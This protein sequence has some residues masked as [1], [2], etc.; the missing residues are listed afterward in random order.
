MKKSILNLVF[1][2]L[3]GMVFIGCVPSRKYEECRDYRRS[4]QGDYD[5]LNDEARDLRKENVAMREELETLRLSDDECQADLKLSRERY[6]ELDNAQR[7]LI[8]RY[9]RR[10]KLYQDMS[11][12]VAG[13][14]KEL[15]DKIS[16]Q[17]KELDRK[18]EELRL[19]QDRLKQRESE[20]EV[21]T[22]KLERQQEAMERDKAD[23]EREKKDLERQKSELESKVSN[24]ESNVGELEGDLAAREKRV[25]ELEGLISS[26]EAKMKELK[27][28]VS[29]ALGGVSSDD[30][31]VKE[32]DGKL[33]VTLSQNLLFKS[34]SSSINTAGK[35]AISKLA[36]VLNENNDLDIMVEGH[37]DSDGDANMNWDL[38]TKRALSVAKELIKG[39]VD[40]KRITSAGRGEHAPVAS[41]STNDGKAMNRRTEIILS[42]KLSELYD[43]IK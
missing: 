9:E 7:D 6:T 39:G 8:D 32:K 35:S 27:G 29:G 10:L 23:L 19:A 24:L 3:A 18:T 11:S 34:G 2:A 31:S 33:Y 14:K 41:N 37:T 36:P 25:K 15:M 42:P 21:N 22:K 26:Q 13:E 43:I 1:A 12:D 38:S 40:P 17:S 20:L 30:L 4:L 5:S 16:L 28:R